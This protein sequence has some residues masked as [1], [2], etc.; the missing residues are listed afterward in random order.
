MKG[1]RINDFVEKSVIKPLNDDK[2][3]QGADGIS[4]DVVDISDP[5]NIKE[6]VA[7]KLVPLNKTREKATDD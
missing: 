1:K 7:N 3:K 2:T 5:P 4:D 6:K